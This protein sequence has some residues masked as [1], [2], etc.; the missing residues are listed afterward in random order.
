MRDSHHF[1]ATR[2]R[3]CLI[4]INRH[5]EWQQKTQ[6]HP[7]PKTATRIREPF[8]LSALCLRILRLK[9]SSL[10]LVNRIDSVDNRGDGEMMPVFRVVTQSEVIISKVFVCAAVLFQ[11]KCLSS[12]LNNEG[13]YVVI[14]LTGNT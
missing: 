2:V 14:M 10:D 11:S 1:Q 7:V 13:V 12:F 8:F 3:V 6:C 4:S 5:F 9:K